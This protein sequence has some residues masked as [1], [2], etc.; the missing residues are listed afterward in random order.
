MGKRKSTIFIIIGIV[1]L[2]ALLL[3]LGYPFVKD[4]SDRKV[5]IKEAEWAITIAGSTSSSDSQVKETFD[6]TISD[7][8]YHAVEKAI[9]VYAKELFDTLRNIEDIVSDD[10]LNGAI[11]HEN[12]KKDGKQFIETKKALD[13]AKLKLESLKENYKKLATESYALSFAKSQG[14][15]DKLIPLFINGTYNI[16]STKAELMEGNL[17]IV[18]DT[19]EFYSICKQILEHLSINY[20]KW[21]LNGDTLIFYDIDVQNTYVKLK[22]MLK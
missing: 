2:I 6:R 21:Y 13:D 8:K 4:I 10:S 9:K 15:D 12:I 1:I 7:K 3:A 5:L 18:N 22:D 19:L 17:E 14:L 20:D 11:G 16:I